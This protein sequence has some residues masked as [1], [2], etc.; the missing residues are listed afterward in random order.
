MRE[1]QQKRSMPDREGK[2]YLHGINILLHTVQRK[3][4]F[5]QDELKHFAGL[6]SWQLNLGQ[7]LWA[8]AQ[9]GYL[10]LSVAAMFLQ[11]S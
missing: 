8:L 2:L 11:R 1:V 4:V 5:A 10:M 3:E 9:Q 6:L 7:P